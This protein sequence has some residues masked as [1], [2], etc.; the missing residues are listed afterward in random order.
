[1][2]YIDRLSDTLSLTLFPCLNLLQIRWQ[3]IVRIRDYLPS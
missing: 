1:M 3:Q 2:Q